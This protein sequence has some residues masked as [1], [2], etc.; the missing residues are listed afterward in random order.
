MI[1]INCKKTFEVS[2]GE[3]VM[4]SKVGVP[5]PTECF[6]CRAQRSFAFWHFGKFRKGVSA[7]SGDRLITTLPENTR[8]PIY[9]SKEWFSDA[10]DPM[11]HG[12]SFDPNRSFFEQFNEVQQKIPRPHQ[13]GKNN[14]DCDWSDDVWDC[15]N[16]Y[17][18]RSILDSE[19]IG[20]SYRAFRC[21]DSY[22]LT[23]CYDIDQ[24]YD[25]TF[26]FNCFRVKHGFNVRDCIESTFLFDCRNV[27]NCFMCFNLRNKQ[28]HILNKPYSKEEYFEKIKAYHLGS[29]KVQKALEDQF[30]KLIREEAVHRPNFNFR[31]E[32]SAGNYLTNCDRCTNCFHWEDA[33]D[34]YNCLRG[35][36]SK[37]SIDIFGS[38]NTE[39]SSRVIASFP[40][41]YAM[42]F[43]SWV[44]NCR[45][46]EYLDL[47][48]ECEDCFGCVG[49]RKK[50]YCILNKQY[51]EAE[52]KAVKQTII[53][54]ME[55]NGEY[56]TFFPYNLAYSGYNLTTAQLYFPK[57]KEEVQAMGALYDEV[58]ES[59][60]DGASP[61][62]LPDDIRDVG[63]G[64]T[65]KRL[66][67]S[68]THYSFNIA[69][70]ELEFYKAFNIA[71]PYYH[72][73][74]RMQE[75]FKRLLGFDTYTYACTFCGKNVEAYYPKEWGY[76]RVA[77][78]ECYQK[79]I[80]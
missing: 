26:G 15:K 10:W 13:T 55:K 5:L 56:G 68:K 25:I 32:T 23:Y 31:S 59:P 38:G 80:S 34:S 53:A 49:L 50:K 62:D 54:A 20:Y 66:I 41:G 77:C 28:Y 35:F 65:T 2:E 52:Y 39:L 9:S 79:N 22:D 37:N 36:N 60:M 18:S 7:L 43:S 72:P 21:K 1:C 29:R 75:R 61:E 46:S 19:N 51:S 57:T 45:N 16:C 76:K 24:S 27:Q 40:G 69:P 70:R 3:R 12:V 8:Y 71:L 74:Y 14:L 47:C 42:K 4:Y 78:M 44:Q 63:D 58:R 64:I 6:T 17:L 33:Q 11:T 67:C 48:I 73:D 30:L